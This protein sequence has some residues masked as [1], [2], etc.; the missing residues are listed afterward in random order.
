[1]KKFIYMIV[2]VVSTAA[3]FGQDEELEVKGNVLFK[4]QVNSM[5]PPAPILNVPQSVS[6]ITDEDILNQ[7]FRA[8]GDIVRYVPGI[9]STQGEGHRDAMVIRGIRTTS[10]FYQD[11]LRDDVQYYRSLYNVEQVEVLKGPNALLFGRGGEGG[12]IH[13]VSKRAIVGESFANVDVGYDS[14][15]SGDFTV[16]GNMQ[17]S[18]TVAL[19]LMAH[20]DTLS[21]H[22]DHYDG[23]RFGINPSFTFALNEATELNISFEYL[24][25]ERYIDRGIPTLGADVDESLREI[26]YGTDDNI[27]TTE[28]TILKA[29]LVHNYSDNGKINLAVGGNTFNK[30]YQ[31]VYVKSLQAAADGTANALVQL[32][33]Y[34][35]TTARENSFIN[36]TNVNTFDRGTLTVGLD[37]TSTDNENE[38]YHSHFNNEAEDGLGAG[39][40]HLGAS[41][42]RNNFLRTATTFDIDAYGNRTVLD[43]STDVKVKSETDIS[44]QSLFLTGDIDL[45]D[46]WQMI[47]GVRFEEVDT[48]I[49]KFTPEEAAGPDNV[50]GNADDNAN[51]FINRYLTTAV[52]DATNE[53]NIPSN[54]QS[55]DSH[56]SPRFGLIFKPQENMSLYLS[57]SESF[58]PKSGDQYKAWTLVNDVVVD[59]DVFKNSELGFKYNSDA[60]LN[61]SIAYFDSETEKVQADGVGFAEEIAFEISGIELSVSGQIDDRNSISASLSSVDA[62]NASGGD[63]K[64]IPE[65]TCSLWYTHQAND[66]FGFSVGAVYQDEQWI[67]STAAGS[68]KLPDYTRV[69]MAMAITP[70]ESDTIRINIENLL[71][72]DY[73]PYSHS[74]HQ[75][76]V[77][78]PANV[79]VSY[80]KRF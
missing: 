13:R 57:Y 14:L 79:R 50:A 7:G 41:G 42:I 8:L 61:L 62:E 69:D 39:G 38:R 18:D 55:D 31:N 44:V 66:M 60:G 64:E 21:N 49:L 28:G 63:Q 53:D 11:G 20:S 12:L 27:H 9:T 76:T 19:R 54:I 29:N 24:D 74:T 32:E 65:L 78:E 52:A 80:N 36:L 22:R 16:D 47:L 23:D 33:G 30:M 35:D 6:V 40:A 68:P 58:L 17:L 34:R 15:G 5:K 67:N 45:S 46:Q 70:N 48:E 71:D 59:P 2:L 25:H 37:F 1:M 75:V 73:Y 43:F 51:S 77:G 4:D 56:L 10:S 3:I 26:T 72:E